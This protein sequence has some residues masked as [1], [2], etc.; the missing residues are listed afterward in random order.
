MAFPC[1][2]TSSTSSDS[3][4]DRLLSRETKRIEA[5][6]I[7]LVT[8]MVSGREIQVPIRNQTEQELEIR[9]NEVIAR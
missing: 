5:Q 8:A 4:T 3:T 2:I 1:I 6:K 9:A 7:T